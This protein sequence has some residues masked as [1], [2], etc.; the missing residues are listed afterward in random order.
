MSQRPTNARYIV[1]I[2]L[3]LMAG[4]AYVQRGCLGPL[5]TT[6]RSDL[7]L[8]TSQTGQAAEIFFLTYALFQ[9]PTGLLVDRWGARKTLLLFG[10]MSAVTLALGAGTL[11][12]GA[13]LGY[14]LLVGSRALMGVAQ[15][16]LFP[17]ATR[18]FATWFPVRRRAFATGFFQ[19]CMSVGAAVG[20]SIASLFLM[21]NV[22]WPWIFIIFSAP[23]IVWSLWFFSWYRDRPDEH[24]S[25]NQAE[26]DLLKPAPE[27]KMA[28]EPSG[29]TPWLKLATRPKLLWLCASQFFRASANV[30]WMA[31][32]A[33]F[34]QEVYRLDKGIAGH[35]SSIPFLGVVVGS[36]GGGLLADWV[37][38]RTGSKRWSRNG[39][40]VGTA[41]VGVCFF[42][43]AY[44]VQQGPY[45]AIALLFLAAAFSSGANA[46]AYSVTMDIGGRYMAVVFGAMNMAGNLGAFLFPK[47]LFLPWANEFGWAA[48]PLLMALLYFMGIVCWCFVNPNGKI[49]EEEK[50]TG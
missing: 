6:I 30:F 13:T 16:G 42:L 50:K 11:L 43:S 17:A 26:K 44:F 33:T 47:R 20:A 29:P 39:V 35:L 19:A 22:P 45:V 12:V 48:A 3:C 31:W 10:C 38:V 15:A 18:C 46:C 41:S 14:Y 24:R 28:K 9:I 25:A 34:L 32:C 37:L 7:H 8:D 1:L 4:I 36:L 49:L 40:A 27:D 5:E 23:G 2:G 21:M